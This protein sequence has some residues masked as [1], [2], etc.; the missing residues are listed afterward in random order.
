MQAALVRL[1]VLIRWQRV[2]H[3]FDRAFL[4]LRI[5][6]AHHRLAVRD[7]ARDVAATEDEV[8]VDEEEVRAIGVEEIRGELVAGAGHA[9]ATAHL[10]AQFDLAAVRREQW[11][12]RL[13]GQQALDEVG[14]DLPVAGQADEDFDRGPESGF[15]FGGHWEKWNSSP[16]PSPPNEEREGEMV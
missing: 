8:G 6:A 15:L 11:F 9:I 4:F 12:L 7:D 1:R 10:G 16:R 14:M 5:E 3:P 13:D 2:E